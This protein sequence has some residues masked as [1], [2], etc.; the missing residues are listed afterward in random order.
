MHLLRLLLLV[1]GLPLLLVACGDDEQN[2][3]P[4]RGVTCPEGHDCRNGVCVE[5]EPDEP[6][7]E[8]CE[9][10]GQCFQDPRGEFCDRGTGSCAACLNDSHC[11]GRSCSGGRC[12]GTVCTTDDDCG[13]AAPFCNP[14][15][16]ACVACRG[17]ADCG[18]GEACEAGACVDLPVECTNDAE[19]EAGAPDRPLCRVEDGRGLCVECR[20]A[21]DCDEGASC[22]GGAC[23]VTACEDSDDCAAFPDLSVCSDGACVQCVADGDCGAGELCV[24]NVCEAPFRCASNDD[25]AESELG[26]IC[27]LV[28]GACVVCAGDA[29]CP[30]GQACQARAACIPI[31]CGSVADCPVGAVCTDGQCVAADPCSSA[32]DCTFD[33]RVPQC[34]AEGACVACVA[35]AHC[36]AGE[37]CIEEQCTRPQECSTDSQCRGGYVCNGGLCGVCR[38]DA[39][40]PRGSCVAGACVD[41]PTCTA[42][43]EC[44]TGVCSAGVCATCATTLD[45]G[46]GLWCDAGACVPPPS[47]TADVDCGAGFSCSAGSCTAATCDG[48]LEPDQNPAQAKPFAPGAPVSGTLCTNDEDWFVLSAAQGSGLT[49]QLLAP[50]AGTTLALAWYDPATRALR[51]QEGGTNLSAMSLP[52][53][54]VG[55]YYLRVKSA[56][57]ASGTYSLF[58]NVAVAGGACSDVLEPN[59]PRDNARPLAV[60]QLHEGLVLCGD[61]DFYSVQVPAG[62]ALHAFVFPEANGDAALEL[63]TTAGSRVG[64]AATATPF[65][66]GGKTAVA[67]ALPTAQTLLVKVS[68]P[69]PVTRRY[70]LYLSVEDD[71]GCD[72]ALPLIDGGDRVRI[73]AATLG[74]SADLGAGACGAGGPERAY[75]VHL[76]SSSR[77]LAEVRAPFPARLSLRDATCSGELA[78]NA[79]LASGVGIL[80][81]PSLPAGDYTL[82]VGG[83]PSNAGPFELA[84]RVLAPIAAPANDACGTALPL[85]FTGGVA[86]ATGTTLGSISD[87]GLSCGPGAPE[88]FYSFTLAQPQ[89]VVLELD[90]DGPAALALLDPSC[91]GE[92][93]CVGPQRQP[94]FDRVLGAGSYRVAVASTSGAPVGY[95]LMASLP[96]DVPNDAC[97]DAVAVQVPSTTFGD[98]TWA[99]DDLSF[100]LAQSCT[101]YF[102]AGNDAFL[103]VDLAANET[104]TATLTPAQG[105]DAALYV[106][107]GCSGAQCL[108]GADAAFAGGPESVTFTAPSAGRYLLVIDGAAGGGTYSLRVE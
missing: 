84:A 6:K 34:N 80:D 44:A 15:G 59:Q 27:D 7:P 69:A 30:L 99:A 102:T 71:P 68:A 106:I 97:A 75:R 3:D 32:A 104:I 64:N 31:G 88:V 61:D 105:Y 26:P 96:P 1:L 55:R 79:A 11:A 85:A 42:D 90:A 25:C 101:G 46:A 43:A 87:A 94:R 36:G 23:V 50:P 17:D 37:R 100:P 2:G 8:G 51:V 10:N 95:Q 57:G 66:G 33:P 56:G 13:E 58:A 78:C 92:Q 19:C 4:C 28:S 70:A 12:V 73:R 20:S 29:D 62:R 103:A 107:G 16:D 9:H 39:Q 21:G 24:D 93:A 47:C 82:V 40:C 72:T 83:T 53:A 49:A 14:A 63:F 74:A 5:R 98:T 60:G 108:A 89:R 22:H 35:D 86:T 54:A 48:D 45:C 77:L 38:T 91:A 81:V 41:A 65:L 18:T 52:P 76:D 67:P